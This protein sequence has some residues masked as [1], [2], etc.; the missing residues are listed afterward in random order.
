MERKVRCCYVL[1]SVLRKTVNIIIENYLK[2]QGQKENL[3][4][5]GHK[6]MRTMQRWQ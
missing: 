4:L 6:E 2:S 1:V 3:L 5:C